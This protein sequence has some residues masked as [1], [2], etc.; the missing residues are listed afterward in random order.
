MHANFA[1][2]IGV[3]IEGRDAKAT[4]GSGYDNFT[5]NCS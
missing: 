1:L 4:G 5:G 3:P 2:N